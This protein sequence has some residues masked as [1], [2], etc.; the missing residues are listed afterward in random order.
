MYQIID[1]S[2]DDVIDAEA[3]DVT[4]TDLL[5]GLANGRS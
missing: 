1:H 5:K 2:Q 4:A 3:E